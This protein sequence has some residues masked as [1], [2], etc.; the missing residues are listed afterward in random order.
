MDY[1]C[2]L[3]FFGF[4]IYGFFQ[5]RRTAGKTTSDIGKFQAKLETKKTGGLTL[6]EISVKGLF[7]ISS[8]TRIGFVTSVLDN[9]GQEL[10][11]VVSLVDGFQEPGSPFFQCQKQGIRVEPDSGFIDW[12]NV[13]TVPPDILVPPYGGARKYTIL[14]RLVDLDNIPSISGG[15]HKTSKGLLWQKEFSFEYAFKEKGYME[16]S[17]DREKSQ[18]LSVRIAMAV[19]MSDGSLDNSEGYVIKDWIKKTISI[20]EPSKRN[21]LKHIYNNALK[22]SYNDACSGDLE[23]SSLVKSMN[24]YAENKEKYDTMELCYEVM[25]ADGEAA[26]QEIE[27]LNNLC[28][29]LDLDFNEIQKIKD[30]SIVKLTSKSFG[31]AANED[32]LGIDPAWDNA[33]IR[34]HLRTEFQKWSSRVTALPDGN[35]RGNAQKML[36]LIAEA[37]RNYG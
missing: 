23:L 28:S 35:E 31:S 12:I 10:E 37:K 21:E 30:K 25:A 14:L 9:T 8:S 3:L 17:E 26:E 27:V 4:I 6:K 36:E 13:G 32:V 2:P 15:F 7:P 20:Y 33:K 34:K 19:A 29:A 11:S 18:E 5:D 22:E 1:I 24:R 16:A